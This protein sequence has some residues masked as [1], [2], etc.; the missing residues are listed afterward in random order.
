M[1][2]LMKPA[3]FVMLSL[4]TAATIGL[5]TLL[6]YAA[7]DPQVLALSVVMAAAIIFLV[8]RSSKFFARQGRSVRIFAVVLGVLLCLSIMCAPRFTDRRSNWN[9]A[10]KAVRLLQEIVKA[11]ERYAAVH[12]GTY[13]RDL[14]DLHAKTSIGRSYTIVYEP[15]EHQDPTIRH[16][17]L[18]GVPGENYAISI[19]TDETGVIRMSENGPANRNSGVIF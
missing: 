19:Y 12:Q 5:G 11:N 15:M 6:W 4:A 13:A 8:Y 10:V 7:S 14:A 16:Y 1:G 18:R 3:A 9:E 17:A 2:V